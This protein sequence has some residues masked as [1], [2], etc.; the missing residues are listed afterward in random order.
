MKLLPVLA[1]I[2]LTAVFSAPTHAQEVFGSGA[3]FQAMAD[4][5][6]GLSGSWAV[7]GN[8]AGLAS[9]QRLELAGSFQNRFLV[10]ELSSRTGLVVFPIQG[11]VFAASFS[12]F[13]KVPFQQEKIG[14]AYARSVGPRLRFG[15]QFNRYGLYL[16]EENQTENTYG[17]EVGAQFM[18]T[19][20]FTMGVHL[21]NPYSAQI[22]LHSETYRYESKIRVGGFYQVSDVFGWA[23]ELE[24]GFEDHIVLK[25]GFEYRILDKLFVRGGVAGK[26][27][28][29]SAGFGFQVGKALFD[30]A[31]TYNQYLGNSPSVSFQYQF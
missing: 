25:S 11:N 18:P 27:Y 21:S 14:L 5:S 19:G 7:F 28:L 4:A 2:L 9:V 3:R 20:K 16:A 12:Q 8:Q 17:M 30:F 22:R 24:N 31:T 6:S 23:M 15:V 10:S 13:G 26:P 1:L 29:L